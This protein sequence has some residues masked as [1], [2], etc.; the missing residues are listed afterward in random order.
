MGHQLGTGE[1]QRIDECNPVPT[2]IPINN[3]KLKAL[4]FVFVRFGGSFGVFVKKADV[5]AKK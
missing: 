1:S 3:E 5:A 2:K 4:P